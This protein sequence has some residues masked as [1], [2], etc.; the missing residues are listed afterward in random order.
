MKTGAIIFLLA[1]S[2]IIAGCGFLPSEPPMS[3][4]EGEGETAEAAP[5]QQTKAP[6][7]PE[8]AAEDII[9]QVAKEEKKYT[10]AEPETLNE[11]NATN[12]TEAPLMISGSLKLQGNQDLCPHLLRTFECDKYELGRCSFKTL[13]G[14]NGFYPDYLSCRSGYDYKGEDLNHKYC[15][16][17]ECRPLEKDNIVYAY[18]G[19]V[20]YAEYLYRV[21]KVEGGIM[22]YYTLHKCGE[23]RKE[24]STSSGC[25]EYKS[26]IK[27]A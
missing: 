26:E 27:T 9:E 16:I 11:S 17:Q 5:Q 6:Q 2:V 4:A 23:E 14:R 10:P 21:E 12:E 20:A 1:V 7:Q 22:T 3:A 13:V 24:F 8:A 19:T 25:R 18:G 15:F